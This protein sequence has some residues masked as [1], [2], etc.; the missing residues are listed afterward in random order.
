M[1]M[2][3][4]RQDP[5]ESGEQGQNGLLMDLEERV[6]PTCGRVL[7]PWQAQCP[8]DGTAAVARD[9]VQR[10]PPPPAHLLEDEDGA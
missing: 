6:C 5:E 9:S 1:P 4:K 2:F 10:M 7:H 3:T 8:D